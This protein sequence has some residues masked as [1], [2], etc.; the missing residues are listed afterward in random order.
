MSLMNRILCVLSVGLIFAASA[1]AEVK[2]PNI[3]RDVAAKSV[4]TGVIFFVWRQ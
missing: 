3:G 2:K 4:K 1:N